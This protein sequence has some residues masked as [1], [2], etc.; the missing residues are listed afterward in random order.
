MATGSKLPQ[1]L[2]DEQQ[3]ASIIEELAKGSASQRK[4]A[5]AFG[6]HYS[7]VSDIKL[8]KTWKSISR[9]W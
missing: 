3:V 4:I 2:L 9:P 7:I 6:I 5:K 8:G 1:A